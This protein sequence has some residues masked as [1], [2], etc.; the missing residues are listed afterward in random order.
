MPTTVTTRESH[1][2]SFA[3]S[4][5][6]PGAVRR[7]AD[8]LR[9]VAASSRPWGWWP[10]PL[11]VGGRDRAKTACRCRPSAVLT[12]LRHHLIGGSATD[13]VADQIVWSIRLPRVILAMLVGAALTTAGTVVQALVR[14][15]LADPFLLGIS[16]GA[17][18]GATTR[19]GH[20]R[21]RSLGLWALSVG[22]HRRAVGGD[23]RGVRAVLARAA[24]SR[25]PG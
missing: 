12:V 10:W 24:S 3:P 15:A 1:E 16:S 11:A 19:A 4:A 6:L 17:S 5:A 9:A 7:A 25:R 23:G 2:C 20:R 22:Q 21:Y 13:L 8:L 18:V 14:N